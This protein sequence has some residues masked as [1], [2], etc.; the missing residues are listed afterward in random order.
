[1]RPRTCAGTTRARRR[2]PTRAPSRPRSEKARASIAGPEERAL[3]NRK[4]KIAWEK[5]S[6]DDLLHLR[7][8]D[9][10]VRIRGTELELRV[11]QLDREL[12]AQRLK[13]KPVCFLSDEW[14]SPG[15]EAAVG[16]PFFLAHPRL[17]A[18][19]NRMMFEVEGGTASWCMRLLRHEAG[20]AFDHA[21]RLSRRE[22]WRE[23]FGS[24]RTK[25]QPYYYEIEPKSRDFVI[26]VPDHYAQAHPVE[27]FAE[28]FAVW[29]NPASNWRSRYEGRPAIKKLRYVDRLMRDVRGRPLPR[30]T[31]VVGPEARTLQSTLLSYYE[32]KLRLFPLGDPAA[33]ER[34]LKRIFGASRAARPAHPAS[35]FIRSHKRSLVDA[36]A[37]W[38]GERRNQ[39]GR[40]VAGLAQLCTTHNLVLRES[41]AKTLL[42]F[43]TFATTLIVNRLRTHSYRVTGP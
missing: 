25:Y 27:D 39:V 32:K 2:R 30:R 15:D 33:T 43:S 14:L 42:K 8:C 18:L 37:G 26:N 29:L 1:M 21:Y 24:P 41:E 38:S 17:K 34:A 28:T 4:P 11:R 13:L 12:D 23:V 20:H 7:I 9:L 19:E 36:I 40:V 22:D 31:P 10:G 3:A 35:D 16:I 5:L 6:D